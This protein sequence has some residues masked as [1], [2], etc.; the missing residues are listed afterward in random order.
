MQ[1][2]TIAADLTKNVIE[3]AVANS[4]GRTIQR[5]RLSPAKFAEFLATHP[6]T[7]VVMEACGGAHHW[8]RKAQAAGHTVRMLPAHYVRPYR[9]R[10]KTD[11]ADCAAL[12]EAHR[13]PEIH[14][15]AI[16][17]PEQ[18]AIQGLHRVRSTW[19][20]T[21]TARINTVRGLLRELGVAIPV[22]AD[23][24]IRRYGEWIEAAP[25]TLRASLTIIG[26]EI[27]FLTNAIADVERRLQQVTRRAPAVQTLQQIS[28]IGLL[29]STALVAS[30]VDAGNFKNGRHLASWL[31][32]TP[33]EH[34]S[35][36]RRKLGGMS[37]RG[38]GYVRML[39]IHGA[40][41]VLLRAGQ[42]QRA[43]KPLNGLQRWAL[44]LRQRVGHNKATVG[45]AN[46][47][48][49]IA[50]ACWRHGVVFDPEQ[51]VA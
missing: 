48:A 2:T 15:V 22:G 24:L 14:E 46:K 20:Q 19:L 34:S 6:A 17:S 1:S 7:T 37:K 18:Q 11:R 10:N 49:R 36:E 16:K 40:R 29:T 42:L 26:E 30:A 23:Q 12:L 32:L 4:S 9:R 27:R 47:L 25:T 45:L 35:A 39:L 51:A 41:S 50:W 21:R 38:D 3:I 13:N 31:G 5:D 44:N 33:R 43:D 8:A 28:G